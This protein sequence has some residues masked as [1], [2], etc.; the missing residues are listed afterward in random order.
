MAISKGIRAIRQTSPVCPRA[1]SSC[2]P[3]HRLTSGRT[4]NPS[5]HPNTPPH[6]HCCTLRYLKKHFIYGPGRTEFRTVAALTERSLGRIR[7]DHPSFVEQVVPDL[8]LLLASAVH[9]KRNADVVL[10]K[11]I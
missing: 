1:L 2:P 4:L 9:Q 8:T 10:K 5:P 6:P 11:V 7:R 3:T